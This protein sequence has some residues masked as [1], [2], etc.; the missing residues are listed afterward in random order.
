MGR[1]LPNGVHN[2]LSPGNRKRALQ[3]LNQIVHVFY[4]DGYADKVCR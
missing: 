3:V 2:L 4:S 1:Y